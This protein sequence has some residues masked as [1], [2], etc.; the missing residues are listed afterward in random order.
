[1]LA[2]ISKHDTPP[3]RLL[4]CK[5]SIWGCRY[6][7]KEPTLVWPSYPQVVIGVLRPC[8]LL[9]ADLCKLVRPCP[10]NYRASVTYLWREVEAQ[11]TAASQNVLDKQG[12]LVGEADPDRGRQ[13]RGLAEVDEVLE[14]EGEGD[15]LAKLDL[16][17]LVG[18]LHARM[19][20][21][22]DRPV[23]N[24]ALAGELDAV[25]VCVD[26]DCRTG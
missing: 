8:L 4:F 5:T 20:P 11:I 1:M 7:C 2:W 9:V 16:D 25:L 13:S 24:V 18:L 17:R 6:P 26:G 12:H 21:Q 22:R 15:G 10:R 3:M 19:L 23:A 14:G